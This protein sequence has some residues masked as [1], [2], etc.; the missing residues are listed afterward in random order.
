MG[1]VITFEELAAAIRVALGDQQISEEEAERLTDYLLSFFG[2]GE[3]VIDNR[4]TSNDRDVFYTLE[5]AGILTTFVEEVTMK[6]GRIW[7]IHYWLLAKDR[8]RGFLQ[9]GEEV[10][11]EVKDEMT[12]L[13]DDAFSKMDHE[14]EVE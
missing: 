2:F 9:K 5:T 10:E 12:S 11:D 13:Y 4:L 8:I 1:E 6:K 7:R 14:D 3:E